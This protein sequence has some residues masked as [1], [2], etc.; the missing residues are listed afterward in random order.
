MR[1]PRVLFVGCKPYTARYGRRLTGVGIDYWTTDIDPA[2][3]MWGER[4]HHI[5][6]DVT[7][8]DDLCSPNSFDAV[9]LNGVIGDGTG[10]D[11]EDQ[12]NRAVTA[13]A[14]I[15]RPNGILLIGW[16]SSK[17]TRTRCNLKQW[18]LISGTNAHI[19]YRRE[20]LLRYGSRL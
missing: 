12:M 18:R 13:I 11:E 6:G 16:N 17:S 1:V 20:K 10:L 5:V 15:L 14:R 3:A 8:I 9:L 4:N 7:L 19:P 2:A